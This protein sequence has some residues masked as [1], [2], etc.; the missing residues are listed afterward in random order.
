MSEIVMAASLSHAP[1]VL[2]WPDAPNQEV[3]KEIAAAHAA[4]AEAIDRT[5]PDVFIAFLDDHFENQFRDMSP[6]FAIGVAP[7]NVGPAKHWLEALKIDRQITV[8]NNEKLANY[9]LDGLLKSNFDITRMGELDYGNN[10]FVPMQMVRPQFDIPFVP[11]YSNVFNPPLPTMSRAYDLGRAIRKLIEAYPEPLKVG[12]IASGGISH[13]PPFWTIE[14]DE[15]DEFIARMKRYQH[16]GPEYLKTDP[17]LF[18]DLAL[19][20]QEM[21][22]KAKWPFNGGFRLINEE[23]DREVLKAF[24]EGNVDYLRNLTYND[25]ERDGGHGGHEMLN[26]MA[27]MGAMNGAGGKLLCY[28]PVMEWMCGMGYMLYEAKA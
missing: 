22:N 20:E 12:L 26:W 7:E 14:A 13:W 11:V 2:G 28:A 1:G 23:W 5:R 16:K 4:V 6:P 10:L 9:L 18:S 27:L 3:Q 8:P 21:S 17:G 25:I 15:S 19:Y 24:E